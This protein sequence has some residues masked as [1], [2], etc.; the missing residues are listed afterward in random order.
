MKTIQF[1]DKYLA[2]WVLPFLFVTAFYFIVLEKQDDSMNILDEKFIA[3]SNANTNYCASAD[4]LNSKYDGDRLQGSC[5]SK[6]DSHRYAEQ[7]D[8]LKQY[9]DIDVIPSDPYDIKASLAKT[10][11]S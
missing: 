11:V 8:G 10:L 7:I 2:L 1:S 9:S 4:F 6:M 3:L 5:C